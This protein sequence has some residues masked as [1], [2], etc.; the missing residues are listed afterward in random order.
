MLLGGA[1]V[2]RANRH[3]PG[4]A[5][6][7]ADRFGADDFI[8]N[9]G[10]DCIGPVQNQIGGGP[11]LPYNQFY[12]AMKQWARYQLTSDPAQSDLVFEVHFSCVASAAKL[13]EYDS[14]FRVVIYD[15]K[16]HFVLWTATQPVE[17]AILSST[18]KKNF[19][20]AANALID[21][22]KT[23]AAAGATIKTQ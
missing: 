8:S 3:D 1:P 15:V 12:A 5:S 10:S 23:L 4:G 2:Y 11:D 13:G 7:A 20:A 14:Q 6:A 22:L 16:T 18:A 17:M 21:D 19:A 9:G